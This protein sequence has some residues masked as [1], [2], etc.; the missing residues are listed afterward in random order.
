MTDALAPGRR[1]RRKARLRCRADEHRFG[2]PQPI[3]G[4]IVRRVCL[5]CSMVSIDLTASE[6]QTQ[7]AAN[8]RS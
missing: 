7:K 6:E 8:E 4:G 5:A 1:N 2:S 3:G